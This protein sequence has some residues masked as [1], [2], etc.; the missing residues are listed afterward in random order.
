MLAKILN[1][2]LPLKTIVANRALCGA[3][4][5]DVL[6]S[7]GNAAYDLRYV[8]RR[9]DADNA[10]SRRWDASRIIISAIA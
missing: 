6:P 5:N 8:R 2:L 4:R 3:N 9:S 7:S 1:F 10:D